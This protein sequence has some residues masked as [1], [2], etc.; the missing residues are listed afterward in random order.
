MNLKQ[1]SLKSFFKRKGADQS[2]SEQDSSDDSHYVL[3]KQKSMFGQPMSWTRVREVYSSV[4]KRVTI[5]DV[6]DDLKQDRV[7]K[8]IRK[9]STRELG[10]LLFDPNT[11]NDCI[12]QLQISHYQLD[13]ESLKDYA[14]LVSAIR[15]EI[16]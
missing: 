10:E 6:E 5:F 1:I 8:Q 15:L 14:K 7:L 13:E 9:D 3:S 4:N 16:N 12:E 2:E 11:F